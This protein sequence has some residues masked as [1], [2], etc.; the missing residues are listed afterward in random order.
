[1][2]F[3]NKFPTWE[4]KEGLLISNPTPPTTALCFHIPSAASTW[5][6][7][8]LP[9][10]GPSLLKNHLK[11]SGSCCSTPNNPAHKGLGLVLL[12]LFSLPHLTGG[13]HALYSHCY[14]LLFMSFSPNSLPEDRA[15]AQRLAHGDG[16]AF[17]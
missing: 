10:A 13:P 6:A 15:L 1:M 16:A 17:V 2:L 7:L 14:S 8:S 4:R 5:K 3:F 9:W 11:P 12:H